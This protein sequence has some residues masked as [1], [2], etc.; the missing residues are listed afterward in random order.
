[1][2]EML[3]MCDQTL[4]LLICD[5]YVWNVKHVWQTLILLICDIYVW[6]V[7]HVWSDFDS[8][9]LWHLVIRSLYRLA[10]DQP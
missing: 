1:M 3:N 4:I 10:H 7:K 2:F 6:N 9:D 5:I 8:T